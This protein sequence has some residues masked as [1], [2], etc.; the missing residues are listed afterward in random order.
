MEADDNITVYGRVFEPQSLQELIDICV[1]EP[2]LLAMVYMWRGQANINWFLHS[3]AYR[4]LAQTSIPDEKTLI[5]Y[6]IRLLETA[7][8]RGFR[9][10]SGR[11]LTDF[12]LLARLQHHG[13]A[14]RLLDATRSML[15]ALYFA[16]AELPDVDGCLFGISTS[17]MGGGER[18]LLRDTYETVISSILD[19]EYPQTWQA[20]DVSPRIAAQHSQFLYS[21]LR[22]SEHGSLAIANP[23]ANLITIRIA[24]RLKQYFL[25]Q[26]KRAFDI[27]A[28]TLFPDLDGF[29]MVNAASKLRWS[30]ERW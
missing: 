30:D 24:A 29:G 26:L 2:N 3:A 27:S 1:G 19:I 5:E 18:A 7:T 21:A 12:E 8:H 10:D 28:S 14:T 9:Y 11:E 20:P 23:D 22:S 16:C 4:R 13:A 25:L 15:V 6:E 17:T